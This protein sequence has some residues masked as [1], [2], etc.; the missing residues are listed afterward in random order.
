MLTAATLL[1]SCSKPAV[2]PKTQEAPLAISPSSEAVAPAPSAS[3]IDQ[4]IAANVG[5]PAKFR[6][7]VTALKQDVQEHDAAA[8]AALISYPITINPRTKHAMRIRT[9]GAF[10]SSYDSIITPH[11][12]HVIERQKYEDLFVNYQ[13]AMFGSGEIWIAGICKD[14]QCK[15]TEIKVKT[16]QNTSP[17]KPERAVPAAPVHP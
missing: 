2:P 4:S 7:F 10:I 8:V 11:I 6:Q 15:Q 1:T 12:A 17:K 9:P 16:I 14:K 13:G 5:D 3:A